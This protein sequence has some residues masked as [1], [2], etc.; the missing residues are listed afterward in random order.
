MTI[1]TEN[2]LSAYVCPAC[3][4]KSYNQNDVENWYCGRCHKTFDD[5]RDEYVTELDFTGIQPDNWPRRRDCFTVAAVCQLQSGNDKTMLVHAYV[6]NSRRVP[7]FDSEYVQ[8]AWVETPGIGT[9]EDG[10][11]ADMTIVVDLTQPHK[12]AR[13]MPAEAYYKSTLIAQH[14]PIKRYTL[15]EA[16]VHAL[17]HGH[18]GPWEDK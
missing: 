4:A 3:G 14:L 2:G 11:K 12:D 9:Y 18:D 1:V 16:I 10:S 7:P 17:V 8:H 13:Y 6:K 5:L 15:A